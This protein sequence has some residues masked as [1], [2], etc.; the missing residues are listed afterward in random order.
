VLERLP[1]RALRHLAVATQHPDAIGRPFQLLAGERDTDADGK[2]KAERTGC[3][4]NPGEQRR[5]MPLQSA[6]EGAEAEQLLFRDRPRRRK[7]EYSS[8]EACPLEKIKWSFSGFS[9]WSKS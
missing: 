1:D 9:G 4:V 7:S 3:D 5:R 6:A 8:G 2:P